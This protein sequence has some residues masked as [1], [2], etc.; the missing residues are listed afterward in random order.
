M[1]AFG[2]H[3]REKLLF[4]G[5]ACLIMGRELFCHGEVQVTDRRLVMICAPG[6]PLFSVERAQILKAR[7][8]SFGFIP[9]IECRLP[10]GVEFS[11]LAPEIDTL[12]A[13]L[14]MF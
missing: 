1:Q 8:T 7:R 6:I 4:R 3:Q 9:M 10:D 12:D 13:I 2:S 14:A 5:Q 11:L